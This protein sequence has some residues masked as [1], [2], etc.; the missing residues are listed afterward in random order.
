MDVTFD[1]TKS[2]YMRPQLQGESSF[3]AG[4]SFESFESSFVP[5]IE[6]LSHSD[7]TL[8]SPNTSPK[9]SSMD[10]SKIAPNNTELGSSTDSS[11][12]ESFFRIQYQRRQKQP[13]SIQEQLQSSE[14]RVSSSSIDTLEPLENSLN[15][16]CETDLDDLPIALR[17][18]TRSCTKYPISHFVT[19]KHLSMQHQSFLS[20]IDAIRVPTSVQE[21]L[22]DENWIQAMNEEMSALEKNQ[23][24]EIVDRS[25]DKKSVGC[26]WVFSLKYKSDGTLDRYKARLVAKGYTQTYGVDYEETFALVAKMNT[27]RI[28]LSLIAYFGWELQQFDVKNAFLDGNLEEEIY[29]EIPPGFGSTKGGYKVC[30]L[31]KAL[32]GLQQSPRAWFG[33]LTQAMISMGYRQSQ[34]DHTM[35]TKHSHEGKLTLLLVYVDDMIVTGDDEHDKQMLKEKLAAQFEMKDLGKLKYFL[36]IDVAYSKKGIFIS[37][38]KYVIDLLKETGMINCKTTGVPIEQNHRIGSHEGS[39]TV[40]KGQYLRL[41]KLIYLAHTRP[42][43]AYAVS[44]VSQFMHDPRERHIYRL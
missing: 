25:L 13:N 35:F 1:E 2:F 31:K 22:K 36:E 17:K 11:R 42:D 33:R 14:P 40:N 37:Q 12:P 15:S 23:T 41:G 20:A 38:R 7:N 4:G 18:G 27:V 24:W 28:I 19:T 44:V 32:Y 21:A 30:R 39:S 16:N 6:E 34:G 9:T 29:M 8:G 26:K 3:E 5:S 43:I 10:V